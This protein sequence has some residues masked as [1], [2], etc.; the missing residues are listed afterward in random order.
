MRTN[1][2]GGEG[3]IQEDLANV[4]E[5]IPSE[6]LIRLWKERPRLIRG[7]WRMAGGLACILTLIF[8]GMP[9]D[10]GIVD[11]ESLLAFLN[12]GAGGG[13]TGLDLCCG[14]TLAIRVWDGHTDDREVVARYGTD[15]TLSVETLYSAVQRELE[16]RG[17]ST[18]G[19][20]ADARPFSASVCLTSG[21]T[22]A[23]FGSADSAWTMDA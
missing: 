5:R 4:F 23:S 12:E 22:D 11:L 3:R 2:W 6:G 14:L 19:R 9:V 16:R 10:S 17:L 18:A 20:G 1:R 15:A 13:E 8:E 21:R 7:A